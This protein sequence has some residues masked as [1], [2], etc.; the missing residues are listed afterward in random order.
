MLQT[1]GSH[2]AGRLQK[3][4]N[5]A[6]PRAAETMHSGSGKIDD[7]ELERSLEALIWESV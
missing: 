4:C 1:V 2:D 3:T 6:D 7:I 5:D